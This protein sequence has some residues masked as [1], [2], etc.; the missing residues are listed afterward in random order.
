MTK[1][2]SLK[3]EFP[4]LTS[5]LKGLLV[6]YP[7][8]LEQVEDLQIVERC[9][10]GD[11]F[12]STIY[13]SPPPKGAWENEHEN[14]MLDPKEGMVILDVLKGKI[15]SI[16]ILNRDEIHQKLLEMMP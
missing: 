1:S 11:D 2:F 8:L 5:E 6:E 13:T 4:E 14:I 10:C 15:V 7:D 16:E 3:K 12:C 9:R